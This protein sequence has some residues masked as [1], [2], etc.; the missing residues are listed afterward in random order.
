MSESGKYRI[1]A[2]ADM[3][4]VAA[5]TLRAWERRY[6]LPT[7]Q[8]TKSSYRVY[9]DEDVALIRRLRAL[10]DGG[11]APADAARTLKE[12]AE[13]EYRVWRR[14]IGNRAQRA[15]QPKE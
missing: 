8:R 2:V 6:G 9:S 10:C 1:Q 11:M 14:T 12:A 7:P 5:A 15:A 3:T 13:V 4:G